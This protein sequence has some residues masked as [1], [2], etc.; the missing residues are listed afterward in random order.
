[1]YLWFLRKNS[2]LGVETNLNA[3]QR[4]EVKKRFFSN[5]WIIIFVDRYFHWIFIILIIFGIG[6]FTK[7]K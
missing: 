7:N 3:L 6:Q 4:A 2:R 1:M 5:V